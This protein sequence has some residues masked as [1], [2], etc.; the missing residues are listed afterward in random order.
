MTINN[1]P[2]YAAK[3]A[4]IVARVVSGELWFYG[5]WNDR[6][7]ANAVAREIGNGIVVARDLVE[8]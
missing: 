4:Y 6:N 3:Y 2:A 7:A 1:L 8:G 5:A